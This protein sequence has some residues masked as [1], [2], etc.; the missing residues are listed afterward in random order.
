MMQDA[1]A[2]CSYYYSSDKRSVH[3]SVWFAAVVCHAII[4][5]SRQS[6]NDLQSVGEIIQNLFDCCKF[7]KNIS[8]NEISVDQVRNWKLQLICELLHK[9][10]GKNKY[11]DKNIDQHQFDYFFSKQQKCLNITSHKHLS[12]KYNIL[13]NKEILIYVFTAYYV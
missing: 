5:F 1:F 13:M 4:F 10:T 3:G 9:Y 12:M 2:R 8:N 6:V 7:T 11:T